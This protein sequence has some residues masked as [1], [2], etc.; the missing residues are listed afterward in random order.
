MPVLVAVM[1]PC[2][3]A[4]YAFMQQAAVSTAACTAAHFQQ[5]QH[6][7]PPMICRSNLSQWHCLPCNKYCQRAS[8]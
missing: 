5:Q 4:H 7:N 6:G 1:M 3:T 8:S 2:S